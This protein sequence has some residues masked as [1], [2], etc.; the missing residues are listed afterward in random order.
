MKSRPFLHSKI[1]F[2]LY[3]KRPSFLTLRFRCRPKVE[4]KKTFFLVS[5]TFAQSAKTA[6]G[7][8]ATFDEKT[9]L[10]TT[11]LDFN[12]L[13]CDQGDKMSFRKKSPKV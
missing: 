12:C 4:T 1:I 7:G 11:Q 6:K 5:L 3:L 9:F 8:T 13:T 10:F 2:D